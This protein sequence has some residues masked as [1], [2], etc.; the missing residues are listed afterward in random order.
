ME[1]IKLTELQE[2]IKKMGISEGYL[3]GL[4]CAEANKAKVYCSE[5][6][7]EDEASICKWCYEDAKKSQ[8]KGDLLKKSNHILGCMLECFCN[9]LDV[10][11]FNQEAKQLGEIASKIK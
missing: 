1:P 6:N 8:L 5:C 4:K 9:I 7:G 11:G 10:R 2:E 3:I